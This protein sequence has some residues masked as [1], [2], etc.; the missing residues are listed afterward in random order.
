MNNQEYKATT[1]ILKLGILSAIGIIALA[2]LCQGCATQPLPAPVVIHDPAPKAQVVIPDNPY[3]GLNPQVAAAIRAG[4]T[5]V[6]KSGISTL[7]AYSPDVLYKVNCSTMW[8]TEIRL[9]PDEQTDRDAI[10]IGDTERWSIKVG[11]H[12]VT[13]KP[14]GTTLDPKMMTDLIIATDK[15]RSYH[16]QLFLKGKPNNAIGFYFPDDIKARAAARE[17]ALKEAAKQ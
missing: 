3:A 2:T 17:V 13:V 8:A 6:I 12:S 7:Y 16:F 15:P 14:L 11:T 5:P 9:N 10:T 1:T 4:Q